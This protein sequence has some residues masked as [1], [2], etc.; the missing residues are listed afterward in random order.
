MP[1]NGVESRASRP[2][3]REVRDAADGKKHAGHEASSIER[4]VPD[5][6]RLALETEDDLLVGHEPS[7]PNR[8]DVHAS[9]RP[10]APGPFENLGL[11]RIG[12]PRPCAGGVPCRL[13]P[14]DGLERRAGRRVALAVV[15]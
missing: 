6:E 12:V 10:S 14:A 1:I 15:V 7:Q 9:L 11:G 3:S 4:V 2:P 13:E 5:R 8:V